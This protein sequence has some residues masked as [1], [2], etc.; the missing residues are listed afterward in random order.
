VLSL[1]GGYFTL[2][3]FLHPVLGAH[4]EP[5]VSLLVKYLPTVVSLGSIVLAYRIYVRD[6]R[7]ADRIARQFAGIRRL[8]M[9]KYYVDELY[10]AVVVRPLLAWSNWLWRV[11][12][13]LVIDQAVNGAARTVEANGSWLRLWQT[14]NVQSYALSFLLGAMV[15]LGYYLW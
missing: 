2:L 12:D 10:N 7:M 1:I 9:N 13:T 8:L 11:W 5:H 15:I 6:P 14:G 4:H 3:R